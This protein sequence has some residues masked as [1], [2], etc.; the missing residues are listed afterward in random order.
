MSELQQEI[1]TTKSDV[2]A[3]VLQRKI[4][5]KKI[6]NAT[7][8]QEDLREELEKAKAQREALSLEMVDVQLGKYLFIPVN[9]IPF[10]TS[11]YISKWTKFYFKHL[12]T[13][14]GVHKFSIASFLIRSKPLFYFILMFPELEE[15]KRKKILQWD[16]IKRACNIYKV[17][18]DIHISLQE[19]K[20]SQYVKITFFTHDE[21]TKDKYFVKLSW[22]D[23]HWSST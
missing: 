20:D 16:A 9:Q 10:L 23:N 22:S 11:L 18:L 3:V 12:F 8:S 17:N 1:G 15:R 19:E 2:D 21:A 4:I 7:K 5:D 14:I 6:S 13:Q